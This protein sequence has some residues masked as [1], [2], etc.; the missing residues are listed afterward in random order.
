MS[1]FSVRVSGDQ[2]GFSAAHFITL[3]DG[4]QESLHGHDYRATVEVSGPLD[5]ACLRHRFHCPGVTC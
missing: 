1:E 3:A 2:F 5:A 4:Q